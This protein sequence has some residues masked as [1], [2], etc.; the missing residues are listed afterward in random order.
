M[1]GR[2]GQCQKGRERDG[3]AEE[4]QDQQEERSSELGLERW[5]VA[6]LVDPRPG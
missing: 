2:G 3:H 1:P 5:L 6:D 4:G